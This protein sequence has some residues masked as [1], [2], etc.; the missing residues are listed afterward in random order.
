MTIEPGGTRN[1]SV[2]YQHAG[3]TAFQVTVNVDNGCQLR[4]VALL[5][6]ISGIDSAVPVLRPQFGPCDNDRTFSVL[7]S[8]VLN[9]GV[10]GIS[11]TDSSNVV[12]AYTPVLPSKQVQMHLNRRDPYQDMFYKVTVTDAVGNTVTIA[13][14]VGGFTL[15]VQ[16][17]LSQQVGLRVNRPWLFPNLVYGEEQCDTFYLHNYGLLTLVLQ[18]PR[19][20][21]NLDYS[22]PPEQLPIV[23]KSGEVRPLE[24]CVSSR[25]FGEQVDTLAIDFNCGNPEELVEMRTVVD[26]LKGEGRDRCGNQISYQVDGFT[27]QNFL[28]P[29]APNPASSNSARIVLGLNGPQLVTLVLYDDFGNEVQRMLN[30]DAMPGGIAALDAS[31]GALPQGVY[32]LR[33]TTSTGT[34]TSQKMVISR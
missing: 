27:R 4:P 24:I 5:P 13:D 20:I 32:H 2:C 8:G 1:V 33:M 10:A 28:Q 11:V 17:G 21:G 9:S 3:D 26:P 6:L 29:P 22:I 19:I 15:A 34:S 25:G 30:N 31:I 16:N 7:E 23:L 12:F 14:T 18:R